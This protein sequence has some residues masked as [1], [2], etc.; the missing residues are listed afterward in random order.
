L[1]NLA[2]RRGGRTGMIGTAIGGAVA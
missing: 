2:A 1:S